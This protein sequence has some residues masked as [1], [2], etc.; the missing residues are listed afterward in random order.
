MSLIASSAAFTT[1]GSQGVWF[2]G[3]DQFASACLSDSDRL[4]RLIPRKGGRPGGYRWSPPKRLPSTLFCVTA[5]ENAVI[6]DLRY[7]SSQ[8]ADG[9]TCRLSERESARRLGILGTE[10]SRD[11]TLSCS[12][13]ALLA[14]RDGSG[15]D[16]AESSEGGKLS[17]LIRPAGARESGF[18]ENCMLISKIRQ[19]KGKGKRE[20]I[21]GEEYCCFLVS[22]VFWALVTGV[23]IVGLSVK[24]IQLAT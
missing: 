8:E 13:S 23:S 7:F 20:S 6:V 10:G 11:M 5:G 22:W 21:E 12:Y 14:R 24:S 16:F 1:A 17:G 3:V 9:V 19:S 15:P 18:S 2:I 4:G